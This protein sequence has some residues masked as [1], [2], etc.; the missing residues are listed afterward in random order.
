MER[1]IPGIRVSRS[2]GK[3]ILKL[4]K[5]G[6]IYG[7]FNPLHLSHIELIKEGLKHFDTLHI[8][9][10]SEGA[11]DL[12]DYN[13]KKQWLETLSG[14]LQ[15]SLKVY[16]FVFPKDSIRPDGSIDLVRIFLY[17][18]EQ[19]ECHADGLITG[20]DKKDWIE[21]LTPAFPDREFMILPE[22]ELIDDN[23]S[24]DPDDFRDRIPDYV[25]RTLKQ[26]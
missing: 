12:V 20:G 22:S 3:G 11:K 26:S 18:Q 25:Y 17:T 14:E 23:F 10:R 1:R 4:M 19:I 21:A 2:E 13:T 15:C 16:P 6:L 5:N 7:S 9:V 24:G 8:F